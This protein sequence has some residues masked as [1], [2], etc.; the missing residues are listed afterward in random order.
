MALQES[1][2]GPSVSPVRND[3]N[4]MNS[5]NL[6]GDGCRSPSVT[7]YTLPGLVA[8]AMTDQGVYPSPHNLL[9][10]NKLHRLVTA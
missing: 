2:G 3:G 6:S 9:F 10:I 4:P 5:K 7:Y 1:F 8:V